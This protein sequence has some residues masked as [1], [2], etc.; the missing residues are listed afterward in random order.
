MFVNPFL[1]RIESIYKYFIKIGNNLQ[2]LF[3]LYMRVT[4]GQQFVQTGWGKLHAIDKT[5]EFFTSLHI[6]HPLFNAY[7]VGWTETLCGLCLLFGFASRITTI[8][9]IIVML[10]ALSTSHSPEISNFQFLLQPLSLV[11][12]TPYP[13]LITCILVFCFGPGRISIDACLKRWAS[14]KE[15][16]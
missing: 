12:Q 4:W 15:R 3:L 10:T 16:Y 11:R 13:F 1:H 6:S 5:A 2:S 9:L 8:P 7:L 14:H